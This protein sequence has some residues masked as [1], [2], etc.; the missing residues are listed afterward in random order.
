MNTFHV[1]CYCPDALVSLANDGAIPGMVRF[2]LDPKAVT[3]TAYFDD[4]LHAYAFAHRHDAC[5]KRADGVTLCPPATA[6]DQRRASKR[7]FVASRTPG[8]ALGVRTDFS[9]REERCD[10]LIGAREAKASK[11]RRANAA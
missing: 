8:I 11:R 2:T 1:T 10:N 3:I 4:V 6:E 7:A 9:I 5:V